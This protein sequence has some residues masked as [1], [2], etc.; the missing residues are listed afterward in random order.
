MKIR[1]FPLDGV[2]IDD[3][4]GL[5][6]RRGFAVRTDGAAGL[7]VAQR[8]GVTA[9]IE[10]HPRDFRVRAAGPGG[11][12]DVHAVAVGEVL[13]AVTRLGSDEVRP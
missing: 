10:R 5:L 11:G 4:A 7:A 1:H 13:E 6:T 3:V 12:V 2:T 9:R 8:G